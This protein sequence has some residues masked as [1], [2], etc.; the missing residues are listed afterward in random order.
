MRRSKTTAM[1]PKKDKTMTAV[2]TPAR[3]T[4]TGS[5]TPPAV[6]PAITD[7]DHEPSLKRGR[8][9]KG[10]LTSDAAPPHGV[11]DAAFPPVSD[12]ALPSTF[13][14]PDAATSLPTL[15]DLAAASQTMSSQLIIRVMLDKVRARLSA[16]VEGGSITSQLP[17]EIGRTNGCCAH[18][19]GPTAHAALESTGKW[20]GAINL[21]W[22]DLLHVYSLVDI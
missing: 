22:L 5:K 9:A 13:V 7:K 20:H 16:V 12:A 1:P 15:D 8:W 19:V 11:I 2:P 17:L 21:F 10:V 6:S 18:F 4:Q 14:L 3:T